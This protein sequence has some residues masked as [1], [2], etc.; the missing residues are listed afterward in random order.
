M[1]AVRLEY[2]TCLLLADLLNDLPCECDSREQ[3]A[4]A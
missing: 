3:T 4:D 1:A 2:K